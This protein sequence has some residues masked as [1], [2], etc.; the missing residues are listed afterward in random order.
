MITSSKLTVLLS[1]SSS[2]TKKEEEEEVVTNLKI[3]TVAL[4]SYF[5]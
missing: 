4:N 1:V 2:S 3:E 5:M